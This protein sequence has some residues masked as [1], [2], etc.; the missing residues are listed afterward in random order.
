MTTSTSNYTLHIGD[1]QGMHQQI[2]RVASPK[3]SFK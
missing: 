3:I 1:N 2:L